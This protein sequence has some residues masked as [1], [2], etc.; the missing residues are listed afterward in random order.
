M[1]RFKDPR[2][3]YLKLSLKNI[4]MKISI[5]EIVDQEVLVFFPYLIEIWKDGTSLVWQN[6][7]E[8]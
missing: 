6:Y 8:R 1:I 7:E 2:N 4:S 5:A 3:S